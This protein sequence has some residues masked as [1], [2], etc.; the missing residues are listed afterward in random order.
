[1]SSDIILDVLPTQTTDDQ[2]TTP[3]FGVL[4]TKIKKYQEYSKLQV[5]IVTIVVALGFFENLEEDVASTKLLNIMLVLLG[6]W[7]SHVINYITIMCT[8][9]IR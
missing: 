1:M 4:I 7:L 2:Q 6:M 9:P 5:I 8:I 3:L